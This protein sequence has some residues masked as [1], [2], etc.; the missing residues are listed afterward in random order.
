MKNFTLLLLMVVSFSV[1]ATTHHV[2]FGGSAGFNFSPSNLNASVGDTIVWT[3][4]FSM[5][6]VTST[7]VPA[8][9][10][11][12]NNTSGTIFQYV[13]TVPGTYNYHC[14]IHSQMTG[15]IT[16]SGTTGF[17][18]FKAASV[19]IYPTSVQEFLN[20]SISEIVVDRYVIVNLLGKSTQ[21]GNLV[22]EK[23]RVSDL[24]SGVYF[25]NLLTSRGLI[26]KRF[27]KL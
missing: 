3:G 4:D 6:T 26:T 12:F 7:S 15:T 17:D 16:V 2:I 14:N 11:P 21:E 19:S 24:P 5:H 25:L 9:A 1:S 22:N 13:V 27:Y 8:G 10:L 23:I 20:V 18:E